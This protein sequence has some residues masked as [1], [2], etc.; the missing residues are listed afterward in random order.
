MAIHVATVALRDVSGGVIISKDDCT[1]KQAIETSKEHR[2]MKNAH[3]PNS[4]HQPNIEDYLIL[5][6][7]DGFKLVHMDQYKIITQT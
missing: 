1:I 4:T 2:V 6:D 5:E 3:I 7:A